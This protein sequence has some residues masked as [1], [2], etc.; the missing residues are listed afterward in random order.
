MVSMLVL[1]II[2]YLIG[3]ISFAI[4]ITKKT[5]GKDV[6]DEGSKN[7]GSTNVFRVAG[8][9]SALMTFVC[10]FLKGFLPVIITMVIGRMLK[11]EDTS[12]LMMAVSFGIIIGHMYPIY[13]GFKG[14][15]G[16]ASTIGIML[17]INPFILGIVLVFGIVLLLITRIVSI[18]SILGA[19]LFPVLM[20][21]MQNYNLQ[22]G[23][24]MYYLIYSIIL[25][26]IILF[27]HR[28]N[29]QRLKNGEEKRIGT[30]K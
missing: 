9:K 14:G 11:L 19:I 25:G 3:S 20:I 15:K 7:A 16:V 10:D 4:L 29:I 12:L 24:Y 8:I 6:R 17:A 5:T 22:S 26:T 1:C 23:N 28:T 30:K 27:A 2:G 13:F 18:S 21:F